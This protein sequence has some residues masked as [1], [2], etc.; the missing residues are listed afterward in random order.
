[1]TEQPEIRIAP[2]EP[3]HL[4]VVVTLSIRAWTP[5]FASLATAMPRP[6]FRA[7]YT[8]GWEARQK[9]EVEAV[10]HDPDTAVWV[11]LIGETVAG[12]V[13]IKIHA[14]DAMGEIYIIAVDPGHQRRGVGAA[15]TAF[16]LDRMRQEG[17]SIAMV[18][19][20]SEEGHA[21]ARRAYESAGFTLWPVARYFREL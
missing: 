8:N 21:P 20:S 6:V 5:V 3:H 13:G 7:F 17:L 15:L 19:T 4:G 2:F 10:C 11:A 12:Y 14:E 18:E 16:A 1:M 9:A